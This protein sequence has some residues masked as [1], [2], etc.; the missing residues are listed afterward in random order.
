MRLG[1]LEILIILCI[2]LVL[3]KAKKLPE[4]VRSIGK[5]IREFKKANTKEGDDKEKKESE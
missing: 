3:F 1:I 4:I 5:A 2:I